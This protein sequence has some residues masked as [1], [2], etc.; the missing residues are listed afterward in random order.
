MGKIIRILTIILCIPLC[1][2]ISILPLF[3][4]VHV[5]FPYAFLAIRIHNEFNTKYP[6]KLYT[7]ICGKREDNELTTLSSWYK[8]HASS[9]YVWRVVYFSYIGLSFVMATLMGIFYWAIYMDLTK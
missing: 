7:I 5:Y 2:L 3:I 9:P 8:F 6:I 1:T 4:F